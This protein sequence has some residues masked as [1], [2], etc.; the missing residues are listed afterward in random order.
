GVVPRSPA[1]AWAGGRRRVRAAVATHRAPA[2]RAA[3]VDRPAGRR[4]VAPKSEAAASGDWLLRS[5][6]VLVAAAM[7]ALLLAA[8]SELPPAETA[9]SGMRTR[10]ASKG[11]SSSRI[12]LGRER[13]AAPAR[14][15]GI[16]YRD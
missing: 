4:E 12:D 9:V 2:V 16:S 1:D 13:A 14:G 10:L 11:L 7:V 15:N 3:V 5:L 6:V 8:V